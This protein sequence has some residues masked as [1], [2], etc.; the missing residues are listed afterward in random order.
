M[1]KNI[2]S[3]R[4]LHGPQRVSVGLAIAT[5]LLNTGRI[6]VAIELLKECLFIVRN[7]YKTKGKENCSIR[8]MYQAVCSTMFRAYEFIS[9]HTSA[10]ECGRKMLVLLRDG[11]ERRKEGILS[12]KLGQFYEQQNKYEKAKEFYMNGLRVSTETRDKKLEG[13]CHVNL[14]TV[15]RSLGKYDKAEEFHKK[16]LKIHTRIGDK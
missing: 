14:G 10:I 12:F 9:D 13:A 4:G 5:F 2:I 3:G 16:A 7:V 15:F 1:E 6:P 8:I 11:D